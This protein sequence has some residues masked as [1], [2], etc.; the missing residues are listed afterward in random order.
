LLADRRSAEAAFC[1]GPPAGYLPV[2]R[3]CLIIRP[4]EYAEIPIIDEKKL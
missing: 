2:L 3:M 4:L 1:S